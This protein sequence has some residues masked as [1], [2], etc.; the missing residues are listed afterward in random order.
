MAALLTAEQLASELGLRP[1]T[2][3]RWARA[4]IIPSLRLSGK[5]IRFDPDAVGQVLR[6]RAQRTRGARP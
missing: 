3:K 1:G 4:G 5:V 2:I 6:D